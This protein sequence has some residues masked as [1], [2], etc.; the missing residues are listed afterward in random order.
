MDRKLWTEAKAIAARHDPARGEDLAQD[1]VVK[2]LE[3]GSAALNAPAWLER[4][5]RNAAIDRWRTEARRDA[6][7]SALDPPASTPDPESILLRRERRRLVRGALAALPRPQRRAT[8]A[9]FQAG[10]SYQEAEACLH[11]AATTSRTRVHRAL[12][13]LRVRLSALR[14]MLFVPGVQMS[15]L[16]VALLVTQARVVAPAAVVAA[17]DAPA[18]RAAGGRHFAP[19]RVIAAETKVAGAPKPAPARQSGPQPEPV[20]TFDFDSDVVEG[21]ISR[22]DELTVRVAPVIRHASMIELRRD[23]VPELLKTLE[24]M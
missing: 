14:V 8:L 24:D 4:V 12:A 15:A 22:P 23:F 13:A 17:D 6:L 2:V 18:S 16:G 1:L 11:T 10:L 20:Q 19:A 3:S 9:R 5:A 21:D 7:V